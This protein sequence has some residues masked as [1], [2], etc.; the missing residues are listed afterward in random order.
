MKSHS[1]SLK[2]SENSVGRMSEPITSEGLIR[3]SYELRVK[4]DKTEQSIEDLEE[5]RSVQLIT[6]RDYEQHINRNR[7]N[8]GQWLRYAKWE[9]ETNH[10]IKRARSIYE[11][12]LQVNVE[13]VPFWTSYINL[14]ISNGFVNHAR[15]ILERAITTLPMIDKFW[16]M[17]IQMEETLQN[18]LKVRELFEKWVTWN[19]SVRVWEAYIE[20]EKR[21]QET[22]NVRTIFQKCLLE[23]P[24]G[25]IWLNWI[26]FELGLGETLSIRSVFEGSVDSLLVRDMNDEVLPSIIQKW[27]NW[28]LKQGEIK[29]CNEIFQYILDKSKFKF[30]P[31]QHEKLF[32][33]SITFRDRTSVTSQQ[34]NRHSKRKLTYISNIE[35]SPSDI[36]SWWLLLDLLE[37]D[38]LIKYMELSLSPANVP[39]DKSKTIVWKR[40]IY[41]WIKYAFYQEFV[42]RDIYRAREVWNECLKI[43][44]PEIVFGKIWILLAQFEIRNNDDGLDKARKILGRAIGSMKEPKDKIFKFYVGLEKKVGELDRVR[45]VYQKWFELSLI[46]NYKALKVLIQFIEFEKEIQEFERSESLFR[47]GLKLS[48]QELVT[49]KIT[50]FDHLCIAFINYYKELFEYDRARKL[51]KDLLEEH[52][53]VK[54]WIYYANFES[55]IPNEQQLNE[56]NESDDT[57]FEFDIEKPQKEKTRQVFQDA[58]KHYKAKDMNEERVIILEAWKQYEQ[59]YG[60]EHTKKNVDDKFPQIVKKARQIEGGVEEYLEYV[61]PDDKI[62]TGFSKFLMNAKSWKKTVA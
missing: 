8:T 14:E 42:S 58:L 39:Q 19:P 13:H 3:D 46:N 24:S 53:N 1:R 7:L 26:N 20:F 21:C 15:N 38:E 4:L 41:L 5:L 12:A 29:R 60:D 59:V 34:E 55:S 2:V 48:K 40:Y 22:E 31:E 30:H 36:D 37:G 61:F 28:E 49:E 9:A 27:T 44:P 47:L 11:R 23:Y 45:K 6:R 50:P 54:I 52:D 56:F 17:Y 57:S 43:I 16:F 10:E 35:K 32:N 18:M 51:F 62:D 33:I 25:K